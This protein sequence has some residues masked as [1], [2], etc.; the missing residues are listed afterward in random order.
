MNHRTKLKPVLLMLIKNLEVILLVAVKTI[1][2]LYM[3]I[4]L[5]FQTKKFP[6]SN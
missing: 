5:C 1:S 6:L 2:E 4:Y 3:S